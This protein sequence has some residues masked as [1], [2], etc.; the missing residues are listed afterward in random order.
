MPNNWPEWCDADALD[1][2]FAARLFPGG[3][4]SKEWDKLVTGELLSTPVQYIE[5]CLVPEVAGWSDP[6]WL[7]RGWQALAQAEQWVAIP[8]W[9]KL[10]PYAPEAKMGA[11]RDALVK[12]MRVPSGKAWVRARHCYARTEIKGPAALS[13][14]FRRV[15][16]RHLC[17][18]PAEAKTRFGADRWRALLRF[19]GVS[20]EPKILALDGDPDQVLEPPDQTTFRDEIYRRD[21][22][23]YLKRDWHLEGF[24]ACL[25]KSMPPAT[26]MEMIASLQLTSAELRAEWL[27]VVGADKTHLPSPYR[28]FVEYQLRCVPYLPVKPNI[29]GKSVVEGREAFWPQSGISGVTPNLDLAGF[30]DPKRAALRP[31]LAAALKYQSSLPERWE[32]WLAWNKALVAAVERD[33]VPRGLRS[34]RDFY[35]HMLDTKHGGSDGA[36]PA[37]VVC[38]DPGSPTGLKAVP[39]T[40]ACWIDRPAFAAPD[41]LD[42]L[43]AAGLAYIP[44]LLDA[45]P[46]AS[47]Q[48][49]ISKASE[50]VAIVPSFDEAEKAQPSLERRLEARWRAIAVQCEAKRA[51]LPPRPRLRAVH[52]LTLATSFQDKAVAEISSIAFRNGDEWLIDIGNPWDAVAVALADGAGHAADLRYRFAAILNA[53]NAEAVARVLLEDGIPAYKLASLK[54]ASDGE[55]EEADDQAEAAGAG[56]SADS[57]AQPSPKDEVTKD[58]EPSAPPPAPPPAPHPPP[59]PSRSDRPA[60][61]HRASGTLTHRPIYDPPSGEGS[62]SGPGGGWSGQ[63]AAGITGELW[64]R[65]LLTARL[66]VGWTATLNERDEHAGESDIVVRSTDR[67]WHVEVKTLS[68]ERLY[69]SNLERE[70]AE[71]Q[72]DRYWM[73]FLV[74]QDYAWRIHWSWDPLA[75]LLKCERR[76]QWQWSNEVEGPRL[77]KDSWQPISGSGNPKAPPD[78]ATAVIRIL[79]EHVRA[80]PQDDPTLTLFWQRLGDLKSD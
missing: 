17:G 79:D 68:S 50:K 35:E 28:S 41:V 1:P 52:G 63:Y 46:D 53:R 18:Y 15:A 74:R 10:Q 33:E 36:K 23:R 29:W 30:K 24:P 16:G 45:A 42:A 58:D 21:N 73:C 65:G 14:F 54:L 47:R 8:E 56:G 37:R 5:Q 60:G 76:V 78:R 12:A 6:E 64:L 55:E 11:A 70:K 19:L 26:L 77:A 3:V 27:K 4:I 38:A 75:D 43:T 57:G 20:W 66:P 25:G 62:G 61:D 49:G 44:A 72:R 7:D 9:S 80:L 51:K 34:A 59:P 48:L 32:E 39:R 69:W 71:R 13:H 67:E 31:L 22:I 2:A 40:D